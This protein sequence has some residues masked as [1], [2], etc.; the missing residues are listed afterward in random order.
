MSPDSG[1]DEKDLQASHLEAGDAALNKGVDQTEKVVHADGTI[2][3]L[4]AKAVGGDV[5]EMPKGYF[6]S[7][8]FIGTVTVRCQNQNPNQTS[9]HGDTDPLSSRP[10]VWEVFAP[11]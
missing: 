6:L 1:P 4:D 8:Q 11:I 7:A 9:L 3:Y 2:D 5:D 10:N